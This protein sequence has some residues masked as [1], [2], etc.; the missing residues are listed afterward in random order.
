MNRE[1]E[2]ETLSLEIAFA[3]EENTKLIR[4][5][6]ISRNIITS[7]PETKSLI[8]LE[9]LGGRRAYSVDAKFIVEYYTLRRVYSKHENF[10]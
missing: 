8:E 7:L 4:C 9:G 1:R 6:I 10:N 3:Q 2:R 5:V